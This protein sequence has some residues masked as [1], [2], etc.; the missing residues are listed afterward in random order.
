MGGS[1]GLF[2]LTNR[3]DCWRGNPDDVPLLCAAPPGFSIP[4]DTR[5]DSWSARGGGIAVYFRSTLQSSPVQLDMEITMF[6]SISTSHGSSTLLSIYKCC[7]FIGLYSLEQLHVAEFAQSILKELQKT[8]YRYHT[9][10]RSGITMA[11]LYCQRLTTVFRHKL[12][13]YHL[14]PFKFTVVQI[15]HLVTVEAIFVNDGM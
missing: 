14:M 13:L 7:R 8:R 9:L 3:V 4:R 12:K 5:P 11:C 2:P 6:E 10:S 15:L 1:I